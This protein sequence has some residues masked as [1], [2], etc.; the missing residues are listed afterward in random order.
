MGQHDRHILQN[1]AVTIT[2]DREVVTH[3][4]ALYSRRLFGKKAK[5]EISLC[6][7]ELP[8]MGGRAICI[9]L[10]PHQRRVEC[11]HYCHSG[12]SP[13]SNSPARPLSRRSFESSMR[14]LRHSGRSTSHPSSHRASAQA[15]MKR[16]AFS[17]RF[18]AYFS[19]RLWCTG[20]LRR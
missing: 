15:R 1:M 20:G 10:V 11:V 18:V 8:M 7:T 3:C 5:E 16:L 2:V 14:A 12:A 17:N 4:V 6:R 19:N 13:S 9:S